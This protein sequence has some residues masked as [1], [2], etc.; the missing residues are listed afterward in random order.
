MS[1]AGD[2]LARSR[3]A[4]VDHIQRRDRRNDASHTAREHDS[5]QALG[6]GEQLGWEGPDHGSGPVAWLAHLKRVGSAWWRSHPANLGLELATPVLSNYA[7]RKPGQFLAIAAAIGA[8]AM[9][10]RPWRLISVTGLVVALVKSSQLSG[11]IMSAMSAADF[12]KDHQT[13]RR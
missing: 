3:L 8:V 13:R 7:G 12:T 2:K 11:V 6:P 4:I 1:E 9:V 5:G 10:I